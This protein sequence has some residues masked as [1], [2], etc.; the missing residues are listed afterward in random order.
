[1]EN[2]RVLRFW[3]NSSMRDFHVVLGVAAV[4]SWVIGNISVNPKMHVLSDILT[5]FAIAHFF[6]H[7]YF[8]KQQKFLSD[9]QRMYSLPKKKI[10]KTGGLFLG[11]FMI[12]VGVGIA[13]VREIYTGTL[14]AKLKALWMYLLGVV[15]GAFINTDGLG[16][17]ELTLKETEEIL[18]IGGAVQAKEESFWDTIINSL[19]TILIAI[20]VIFI[21]VLLVSMLVNYIRHKMSSM[22]GNQRNKVARDVSDR[23]ESLRG[24]GARRDS[25]FDFSPN[26]KTRRLYKK[27]IQRLKRRG[28]IVPENLTPSEIETMVSMPAEAPYQEL[29]MIYEKARYSEAGCS[30]EEARHAKALKV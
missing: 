7:G 13:V 21:I 19:Q 6:V 14:M 2:N 23:E 1:M 24:R 20:G 17:D 9:N 25:I 12:F 3:V 15:F 30:E 26:A 16:T 10:R 29:H 5:L 4:A 11:S 27:T 22:G 28:Q 18:G 8:H